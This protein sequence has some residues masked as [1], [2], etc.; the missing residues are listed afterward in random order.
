MKHTLFQQIYQEP[1]YHYTSLDTLLK[2]LDGVQNEEFMIHA[3]DIFAMNDPTEFRYG[4]KKMLEYLPEIEKELNIHEDRYKLSSYWDS[5]RQSPF[6]SDRWYD[7][8]IHL[9]KTFIQYPFVI[10]F[11]CHKD[12]LPLWRMYG[13]NGQGVALGFDTRSY[14]IQAI[15][16]KKTRCSISTHIDFGF[17]RSIDVVYGAVSDDST[18]AQ[19]AKSEY[20]HYW[21]SVQ[22]LTNEDEFGERKAHALTRMMMLGASLIKHKAYEYEAESRIIKIPTDTQN[23]AQNIKFKKGLKDNQIPYIEIGMPIKDL[24]E[25]VIGPCADFELV[26]QVLT[27]KMKQKGIKNVKISKSDVPYRN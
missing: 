21:E 26:Q 12:F 13:T 17:P 3:S 11:S 1:A 27:I 9:M 6:D 2:M 24:K 16:G 5:N 4:Y 23:N 8:H 20:L 7:F 22:H 10:A 25:I 15:A 19:I 18:A 14:V